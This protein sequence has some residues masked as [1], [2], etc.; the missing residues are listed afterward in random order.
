MKT[1]IFL[2]I[3]WVLHN[4]AVG[5]NEN[6]LMCLCHS[7]HSSTLMSIHQLA[8]RSPLFLQLTAPKWQGFTAVVL[9]YDRVESL[10]TLI[11]KLSKVPSLSKILVVWNN[12]RK[13]PPHGRHTLRKNY[14]ISSP[15]TL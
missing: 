7:K 1:G 6:S 14:L 2:L 3:L 11:N 15:G 9:T 10:F 13:S 12:Q 4:D 8:A 5:Y